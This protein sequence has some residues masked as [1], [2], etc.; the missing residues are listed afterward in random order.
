[1]ACD[2]CFTS[3]FRDFRW[4]F[5]SF[6]KV[7]GTDNFSD[8]TR[9]VIA[10]HFVSLSNLSIWLVNFQCLAFVI[11]FAA[12]LTIIEGRSCWMFWRVN[13]APKVFH[14]QASFAPTPLTST[15]IFI[16]E[17]LLSVEKQINFI[18]SFYALY[19]NKN[20]TNIPAKF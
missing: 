15:V 4:K 14:Y 16:R 1:M 6:P 20:A 11:S 13:F 12:S 8:A 18:F 3:I 9:F 2:L 10:Q 7:N 17:F 5:A 19:L